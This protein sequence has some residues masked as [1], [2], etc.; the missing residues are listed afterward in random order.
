[1][2][3][4]F[5]Q[6]N[7]GQY[8]ARST[9][10]TSGSTIPGVYY[11]GA[12]VWIE[13]TNQWFRVGEDLVLIPIYGGS[14]SSASTVVV[15]SGTVSISGSVAMIGAVTISASEAHIG[16]VGGKITTVSTEF[17][18]EANATPYT[19][20]D[21]ISSSSAVGVLLEL[22]NIFRVNGGSG[23]ITQVIVTTNV[24]SVTPRS[25]LNFFSASTVSSIAGDNLPYIEKYADAALRL[26][27]MDIDAMTTGADVT[28]SDMSRGINIADR[29]P[30]TAGAASKSLWVGVQTL[31][32]VTLTSGSKLTVAVTLDN[33]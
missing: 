30:V 8:Q 13:D 7:A 27:M 22:P 25:R 21:V 11:I 17:T 24:K 6:G 20:G 4:T 23:Y 12:D 28:N 2:T 33:N 26:G 14:S 18:R 32:A 9:D 15:Q 10:I 29:L 5:I 1:M 16:E 3:V 31:D 19:A